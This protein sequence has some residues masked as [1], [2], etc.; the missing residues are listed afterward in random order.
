[1]NPQITVGMR[2]AFDSEHGPQTGRVTGLLP[3]I[4]N[5][6]M[7][8]TIEIE[9]E[10]MPCIVYTIPVAVLAEA[11]GAQLITEDIE[12]LRHMLGAVRGRYPRSRWGFRNYFCAGASYQYRSMQRLVDAGMVRQ[13]GRVMSTP[14]HIYFHATQLGCTTA[15]LD[16]AGINRAMELLS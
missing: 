13:G 9:H 10:L 1:M 16:Q 8:A 11:P 12:N 2:V 6:Q 4:G 5:G 7:H 3:C 15:G 14:S